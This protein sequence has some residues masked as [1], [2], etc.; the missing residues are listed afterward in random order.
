MEGRQ[1]HT[2]MYMIVKKNREKLIKALQKNKK[3]KKKEEKRDK[4]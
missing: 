1:T 2:L 3:R 4:T